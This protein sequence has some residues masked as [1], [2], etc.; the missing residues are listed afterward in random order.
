[1]NSIGSINIT[2]KESGYILLNKQRNIRDRFNINVT[3]SSESANFHFNIY[4]MKSNLNNKP[5]LMK[6]S[7]VNG[8]CVQIEEGQD[9]RHIE[10]I[11]KAVTISSC[12]NDGMFGISFYVTGMY[13]IV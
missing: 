3:F 7:E 8:H 4:Y 12:S 1:M 5:L 9:R 2:D 6:I 10:T 13:I 11:T